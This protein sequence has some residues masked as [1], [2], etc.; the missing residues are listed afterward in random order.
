MR[1]VAVLLQAGASE[2]I[3]DGKGLTPLHAAAQRRD[4]APGI[5]VA[6]LEAG[7]SADTGDANGTTSVHW[8][9]LRA[10]DSAIVDMLI[11]A[12]DDPC[13]EESY[14]GKWVTEFEMAAY[15]GG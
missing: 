6:L 1:N 9:A 12:A 8:A 10:P 4:G 15:R 14:A 5:L 11:D 7:G 13:V 3:A 2:D